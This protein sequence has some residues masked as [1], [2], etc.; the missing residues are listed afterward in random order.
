MKPT[1]LFHPLEAFQSCIGDL[2]VIEVYFLK[3]S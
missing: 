3:L 1:E 2:G